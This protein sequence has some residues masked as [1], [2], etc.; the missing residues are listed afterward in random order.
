M[1]D[2]HGQAFWDERYRSHP[3]A[4][5]SGD[6]SI[7][8]V[9]EVGGLPPGRALDVGCGEGA[10]VIWLAKQRWQVTGVDISEVA[11]DRAAA[12]V[13]KLGDDVAS[14]IEWL[15]ADATTFEPGVSR[16]D[17][18]TSHYLHL[19]SVPRRSC[20][21]RL[22]RAVRTGGSLLIV[23]HHPSDLA[24]SVCRPRE[25][26]WFFTGT[27]IA[28]S[29]EAGKWEIVTDAAEPRRVTD[30]HGESVTIH[31]TVFRAV[32]LP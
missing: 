3:T 27:D 14:R 23:A 17:L 29:L 20:F 10:D 18:V 4:I 8:L 11:L 13:A 24:T 7:R 19:P 26:D 12:L 30:P 32:R 25:P 22:A 21:E 5:W 28:A 16:F 2:Q 9:A 31:D 15:H 6:P 1:E